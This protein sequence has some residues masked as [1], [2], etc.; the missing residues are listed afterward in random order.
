MT[1]NQTFFYLQTSD[2]ISENL[3]QILKG[4]PKE[5]F[6]GSCRNTSP[7]VL[8]LSV[9]NIT[10]K[11]NLNLGVKGWADLCLLVSS[12]AAMDTKNLDALSSSGFFQNPQQYVLQNK[13]FKL[14]ESGKHCSRLLKCSQNLTVLS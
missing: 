2:L 9:F 11:L 1:K 14:V 5:K 13:S 4:E 12:E 6:P 10:S 7:L 3:V 8:G